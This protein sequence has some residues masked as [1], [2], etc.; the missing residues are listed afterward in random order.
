MRQSAHGKFYQKNQN[1]SIEVSTRYGIQTP[2]NY[3]ESASTELWQT[4][5]NEYYGNLKLINDRNAVMT[6]DEILNR[7]YQ[8]NTNWKKE[9]MDNAPI[10]QSNI[11]IS[12][13]Q[14]SLI[15]SYQPVSYIKEVFGVLIPQ[16]ETE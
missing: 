10:S 15:I 9:M 11:N 12:V 6:D 2:T 13:E 16:Q 4:L 8:Y 7:D 3:P 5:V 14:I 1:A